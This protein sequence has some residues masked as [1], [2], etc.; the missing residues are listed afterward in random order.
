MQP[1]V[2]SRQY[3]EPTLN[4]G[5]QNEDMK[6]MYIVWCLKKPFLIK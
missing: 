3:T 5:N 2:Y 4:K 6:H 1:T